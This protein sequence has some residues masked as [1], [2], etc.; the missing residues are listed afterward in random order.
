MQD[1]RRPQ[2][3]ANTAQQ[4]SETASV[5][6]ACELMMSRGLERLAIV[7]SRGGL[8]AVVEDTVLLRFL[9]ESGD[10]FCP[11]RHPRFGCRLSSDAGHK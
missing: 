5:R 6:V 7:D 1:A 3:L 8:G 2:R 9:A 4:L 10:S 11:T